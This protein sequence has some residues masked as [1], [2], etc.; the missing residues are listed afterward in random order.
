VGWDLVEAV[1]I[2]FYF[3]ETKERTLEELAEVFEAPNPVKKSL[4]KRDIHSVLNT[5]D[6]QGDT[7]A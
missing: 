6:V 1:V 2:W 4:Q 3:P 5:L 7:K